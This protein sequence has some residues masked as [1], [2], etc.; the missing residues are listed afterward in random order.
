[1]GQYRRQEIKKIDKA[2]PGKT[3]RGIPVENIDWS[4]LILS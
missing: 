2:I 1:M 4:G 3:G